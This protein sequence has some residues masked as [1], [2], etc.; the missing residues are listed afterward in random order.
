[1]AGPFLCFKLPDYQITHFCGPLLASF[2]PQPTPHSTFV[3]NKDKSAIRPALP[4]NTAFIVI[5]WAAIII[6]GQGVKMSQ[7]EYPYLD[8]KYDHCTCTMPLPQSS[9]IVKFPEIHEVFVNPEC[10]HVYDYTEKDVSWR[11]IPHVTP[12]SP[13]RPVSLLV[14]WNCGVCETRTIAQ[15]P[16]R[17]S[18]EPSLMKEAREKWVFCSVHCPKGHPVTALPH[19]ATGG[20]STKWV[21][22]KA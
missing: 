9:E 15:R 3:A 18:S 2:S 10:F 16:T 4:N 12:D 19:D 13:V 5:Y 6:V 7:N 14:S 22:D 17:A 21:A 11:P 20:K 1:L 8:C